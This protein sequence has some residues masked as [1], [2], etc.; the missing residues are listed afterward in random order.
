M[1]PYSVLLDFTFYWYSCAVVVTLL[2]AICCRLSSV[3]LIDYS[4]IDQQTKVSHADTTCR[5]HSAEVLLF[6]I[7]FLTIRW[8]WYDVCFLCAKSAWNR[9][10]MLSWELFAAMFS[11]GWVYVLANCFWSSDFVLLSGERCYLPCRSDSW[12][13]CSFN[14]L[15]ASPVSPVLKI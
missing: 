11:K 13:C 9:K 2:S 12:W 5:P 3:P 15:Y 10:R 1:L 7:N 4:I 6:G 8:F 14:Q